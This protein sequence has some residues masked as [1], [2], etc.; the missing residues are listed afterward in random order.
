MQLDY[1]N[2]SGCTAFRAERTAS[3]ADRH[4]PRVGLRRGVSYR[5]TVAISAN[6]PHFV[7]LTLDA[8]ATS[9][10]PT[11][12]RIDL[13]PSSASYRRSSTMPHRH[14]FSFEGDR[15]VTRALRVHDVTREE[16]N[17]GTRCRSS[18]RA[19]RER[20]D[21]GPPRS[22]L[23]WV[24]ARRIYAAVGSTCCEAGS[25]LRPHSL[26]GRGREFHPR[27]R[28]HLLRNA[29][30][31]RVTIEWTSMT[32]KRRP[33]WACITGTNNRTRRSPRSQ[34]GRN[35]FTHQTRTSWR[36]PRVKP[37]CA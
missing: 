26:T 33:D 29:G 31:A 1:R 10:S 2:A 23:T 28:L 11:P 36:S 9:L 32:T 16:L 27:I 15:T 20:P 24:P 22:R 3:P 25:Y 4:S 17:F 21:R 8:D 7:R 35:R 30:W 19:V 13:R 14:A 37:R 12:N 34:P 5:V 18:A 6:G